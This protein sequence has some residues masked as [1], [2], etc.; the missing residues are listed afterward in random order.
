MRLTNYQEL[1]DCRFVSSGG[2]IE[3]YWSEDER[4]QNYDY[5]AIEAEL[6]KQMT[7]EFDPKNCVILFP[8]ATKCGTT[9]LFNKRE[10][11][12]DHCTYI[13]NIAD[14]LKSKGVVWEDGSK[15]KVDQCSPR[16]PM[17]I[18]NNGLARRVETA[19]PLFEGESVKDKEIFFSGF[20]VE[21]IRNKTI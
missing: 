5:K 21:R 9:M 10:I 6:M 7:C 8:L 11:V 18:I 20:L 19:N 2:A 15:F 3:W 13:L 4:R 14:F 16:T 1:L 12:I 17:L